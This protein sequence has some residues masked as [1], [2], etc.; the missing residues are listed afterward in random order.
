MKIKMEEKKIEEVQCRIP[1]RADVTLSLSKAEV[2]ILPDNQR[3][4]YLTFVVSDDSLD[5]QGDK[6]S[7]RVLEKIVESA[8][9]G[10]IRLTRGHDD[11]FTP[12]ISVDGRLVETP[13]GRREVHLTFKANRFGGMVYPEILE[14]L[15]TYKQRGSVPFQVSVGGWINAYERVLEKDGIYRVIT[16][17]EVEHVGIIREGLAANPRT[18]LVD[19]LVKAISWWETQETPLIKTEETVNKTD[20]LLKVTEETN[21]TKSENKESIHI[22]F[23]VEEDTSEMVK[24]ETMRKT[25]NDIWLEVERVSVEARKLRPLGDD[26]VKQSERAKRYG[27]S[28]TPVGSPVK[29]E[30]YLDLTEEDF[31][32]P[33]NYLFPI[34]EPYAHAV[35][36][37]FHE[38]PHYILSLYD[39]PSAR[40]VYNRALAR[41]LT[42]GPVQF[43]HSPIVGLGDITN[44][45]NMEG[46]NPQIYY[47]NQELLLRKE[48]WEEKV[49]AGLWIEPPTL[50][51]D[52]VVEVLTRR[53]EIY[54]YEP[55][56]TAHVEKHPLFKE[57][58]DGKFADP[59]G[60]NFPMTPEWILK[61]YRV[62]LKPEIRSLYTPEAQRE[63]FSRLLKSMKKLGYT[64]PFDHENPL[65][66]VCYD[67]E[68]MV[69]AE[70]EEHEVLSKKEE[71]WET[72]K[73][74]W[75]GSKVREWL[76]EK[77]TP[78]SE[79]LT[80]DQF[81]GETP[82]TVAGLTRLHPQS[83]PLLP[84]EKVVLT[85][86]IEESPLVGKELDFSSPFIELKAAA[87]IA[88]FL[89]IKDP[90]V[91]FADVEDIALRYIPVDG[92]EVVIP[93]SEKGDGEE[94]PAVS[95]LSI[96]RKS[97]EEPIIEVYILKDGRLVECVH[98][99]PNRPLR[100]RKEHLPQLSILRA[101]SEALAKIVGEGE[102]TPPVLEV[103]RYH[104][105]TFVPG[106][107]HVMFPY[108]IDDEGN[109]VI[110]NAP[111]PVFDTYVPMDE[112]VQSV[113]LQS[114]VEMFLEDERVTADW[115]ER[116][117]KELEGGEVVGE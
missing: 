84:K 30:F 17:A 39:I 100:F 58:P 48:E 24:M 13:D 56:I 105:V 6:M 102:V 36:E 111:K 50:S 113:I 59:V 57:I 34:T 71:C 14:I 85:S 62:F 108:F 47:F 22:S 60:L 32:D 5:R 104:V 26:L 82:L 65:F 19:V 87:E 43:S 45:S 68:V 88:K 109:V 54:K 10:K 106:M 72:L 77:E 67:P 49:I 37:F 7:R 2:N 9:Q 89:G 91:L 53:K 90:S 44:V 52:E 18:R 40:N 103:G 79:T 110:E 98:I 107:G 41:A 15:E 51:E 92:K 99:D 96:M 97:T 31:A 20:E 8:K 12:G 94:V 27:I 63:I 80:V 73:K 101:M 69:G 25:V 35:V 114:I 55:S 1:F 117:R 112:K 33:V 3:D 42:Y 66:W 11:H 83:T 23:D 21:S 93:K 78:P 70:Y 116:V 29:P 4:I 61:S 86:V 46:F 64:V 95:K 28:P 76:L 81:L 75:E 38:N 16:D 74:E 115:K